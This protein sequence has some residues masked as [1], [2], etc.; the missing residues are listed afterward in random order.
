MASNATIIW[1]YLWDLIHNLCGVAG[2]MGNLYAES[3]FNPKN[4]QNSF[5][6]K[7]GYTDET[8]TEAVDSDAYTNFVFDGA[9]YGIAQWTYWSRKNR[10][11]TMAKEQGK[12][13]GDLWLQLDVLNSELQANRAVFLGL[14]SATTV[15]EASDVMLTKF[16]RPADQS[17][18]VKEKRAAYAQKYYDQFVKEGER[19]MAVKVGSARIDE[20]GKAK[21]G[22]AGDQTG[23]E[24]S[25]QNWYKHSK[26]WRVFRAKDPA[27]AEKIARCMEAACKNSKIGYD[28]NQRNTLYN[29]AKPLG[30]DV[31]KVKDAC[32]TDCSALVRVCCAYAGVSLPNFRTTDEAKVLLNSGKFQE[33]KGAKYTDSCDYLKRGDILVTKTQ[34]HTVVVLNDGP[35][36]AIDTVPSEDENMKKVVITAPS[37]NVRKG[38]SVDYGAIGV[39]HEG[40]KLPYF[41]FSNPDNGWHLVEFLRQTGWVSGKYSKIEG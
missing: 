27:V 10:L 26:G 37:V 2:V 21:G 5:E 8:Y 11:L 28:Q 4:L 9:G 20:N 15:R 39:A 25:T 12:S 6:K 41:G 34:G 22:K 38:P 29:K 17:D 31:S 35:K 16:E 36:A 30:F 32:E 40:D 7:L 14:M 24:V 23:K 1:N 19:V 33:M 18:A 3:G 13:V